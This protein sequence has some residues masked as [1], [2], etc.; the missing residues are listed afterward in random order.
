M[1]QDEI[2]DLDEI[3]V[4]LK[5]SNDILL[6]AKEALE[7]LWK[8][9][10]MNTKLMNNSCDKFD[11]PNEQDN[12]YFKKARKLCKELDIEGNYCYHGEYHGE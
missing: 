3:I 12:E 11:C 8:G 1:T 5:R 6:K 10:S 7:L 4:V 2:K 9:M